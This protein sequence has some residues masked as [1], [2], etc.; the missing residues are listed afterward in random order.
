MRFETH[1]ISVYVVQL[2]QA[3]AP[4]KEVTV[5]GGDIIQFDL[6]TGETVRL[7]LIEDHLDL[8][9]IEGILQTNR[10]EN[11]YTLFVLWRDMLLPADGQ[12]VRLSGELAALAALYG[13][14]IFAFDAFG[15]DIYLF[16][17]FFE[18]S[19]TERVARFGEA[20]SAANIPCADVFTRMHGLDG[21]WKVASF[22][23]AD[24]TPAR[25]LVDV[26][27]ELLGVKPGAG[28]IEIKRAYRRL[29]RRYHPDVNQ[30]P[31]AHAKMQ[32]I[33]DAYQHL[34]RYLDGL[35]S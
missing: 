14:Q 21:Y 12:Q 23:I 22:G 26:Y 18:G 15:P 24:A 6:H 2:L 11:I 1:R 33:N 27:Y 9:E 3:A 29:A 13:D 35:T 17:V 4:V 16:P 28:R 30:L 8:Y 20:V 31:D 25:T 5:D 32:Q 7:Y 10:A 19:G 34:L